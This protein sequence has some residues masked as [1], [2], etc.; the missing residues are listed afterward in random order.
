[1][2]INIYGTGRSGT[3]AVQLYV[4]L[5]LMAIQEPHRLRLNYEPYLYAQRSLRVHDPVGMHYLV[6]EPHLA[7]DPAQFSDA[8]RAYLQQLCYAPPHESTVT[9]FIRATGRLS[10]INAIC[11][12][13]GNLLIIRHL[14]HV[15]ES[16]K[17]K[18]F[19]F[20]SL[21]KTFKYDY[22][23][24]FCAEFAED[25]I[26]EEV[27]TWGVASTSIVY[28]NAIYWYV[29]NR[30]ALNNLP[31]NTHIIEFDHIGNQLPYAL[32]T[33]GIA[34]PADFPAV[35]EPLFTGNNIHSDYPLTDVGMPNSRAVHFI[36]KAL[37]FGS[38]ANWPPAF[39]LPV[40]R[41]SYVTRNPVVP[42]TALIREDRPAHPIRSGFSPSER[43]LIDYL[44]QRLFQ[45]LASLSTTK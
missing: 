10:A 20:F 25:P 21:G 16:A 41:G 23:S 45:Q 34:I 18:G 43:N 37:Y 40:H 35:A 5:G 33:M 15:L 39:Y 19:D 9:K 31:A 38:R 28:R 32:R 7:N 2:T 42:P 3:K 27:A 17:R 24:T 26:L 4:T 36:N 11:Q 29:T 8:H 1:M 44:D 6:N 14:S 12:P 30:Y 13:K 22:W